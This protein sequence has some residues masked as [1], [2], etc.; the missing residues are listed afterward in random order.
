MDI[1]E[2]TIGAESFAIMEEHM[3]K[4]DVFNPDRHICYR[5]A[6]RSFDFIASLCM[7]ILLLIPI[8]V[9]ALL[10]MIKDP[11]NPFYVQKR[12][13]K[14]GTPISLLKFRSMG[15]GAD[16]LEKMLT[17]EQLEEYKREFKLKDDPRLLGY[18]KP[19][20]GSRC[21]GAKL[22]MA[23]IDELPQILYN[24][25]IKG[26]M[27]L[28]G[29]RPVLQEELEKYYT[30]EEQKVFLSVKPGITGYWQ[31]H[32]RSGATYESG[33]RQQ[34][35]LYYARNKSVWLDLKILVQTVGVVVRKGGAY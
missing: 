20:D 5:I 1:L 27:S 8:G 35:E 32:G 33:K 7:S 23:S 31:T 15:C 12:V 22:R 34:M 16:D 11:G 9:I 13:G 28:V 21:F 19:G 17:P 14:N 6:K 26:D 4:N 30:P 10:I 29:P 18:K 25:C 3:P 24:V 2:K